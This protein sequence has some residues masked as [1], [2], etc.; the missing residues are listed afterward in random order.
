MKNRDRELREHE[1]DHDFE[2]LWGMVEFKNKDGEERLSVLWGLVN[3]RLRRPDFGPLEGEG[4]EARA[5]RRSA[6]RVE[7]LRATAILGSMGLAFMY[8]SANS[9]GNFWEGA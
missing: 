2:L 7:A 6:I 1:F 4:A 8:L 3:L 5:L 9:E